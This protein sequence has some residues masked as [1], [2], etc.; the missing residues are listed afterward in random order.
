MSRVGA[1]AAL[2]VS[3]V[4]CTHDPRVEYLTRVLD[5]LAAQS[6]PLSQWEL[7]LVDSASK[8][9]L[10][11]RVDLAWHPRARCV[12]E[13]EPGLTRARLRG[14]AESRG[15]LLVFVDDDN[16]LDPEFIEVA[17]RI[18]RERPDIGSW[19]GDTRPSF[20]APPATWTK[21]Y[22]GNLVIRDVPRDLWSNLPMLPD[23]MP[24]GAGLCVRKDVAEWYSKLHKSGKRPFTLDRNG[25]SL[26]SGGDNDLAACACDIGLGVGVFA[27][28]HLTHLIP[29]TRLREEYLL[30]L[31]ENIALS[32]VILRSFRDPSDVIQP[33]RLKTR[34]ADVL[35]VMLMDSRARRF[36]RATRRGEGRA[37]Q[38]LASLQRAISRPSGAE[39]PDPSSPNE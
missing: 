30:D 26:L 31:A 34:A 29:S 5:A 12:R 33:P 6:L 11:T 28:L 4:T 27:A 32:T 36:F 15:D 19:S 35:R 8:K 7:I 38:Q 37:R 3:V 14:I 39:E 25:A 13:D 20:D 18:Y 17:T 9:P 10:L 2:L 16:V 22:W 21:R 23:T 1:E 24:C